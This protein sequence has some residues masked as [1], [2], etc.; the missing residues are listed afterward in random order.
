MLEPAPPPTLF[1]SNPVPRSAA[2]AAGLTLPASLAAQLAALRAVMAR[3]KLREAA[4]A[5]VLAFT[6]GYLAVYTVDRWFDT[7]G[8][9]RLVALTLGLIVGAVLVPLAYLRWVRAFRTPLAVARRAALIDP[10]A[11]DRVL[12]VLELCTNTE[13]LRRSPELTRAA[14]AA[15]DRDLAG[16]SLEHVA[17]RSRHQGLTS[18][19]AVA[20]AAVIALVCVS[21]AAA[22]SSLL[23]YLAP[24]GAV[25]RY[26]FTQVAPYV[27]H[28]IVARDEPFMLEF[29]LASTTRRTPERARLTGRAP[30]RP[31]DATR[32]G[33]RYRFELP[34][35]LAATELT[36]AVGDAFERVTVEPLDRPEVLAL[37]A[38]VRL[39]AYLE[40]PEPLQRDAR[41][42]RFGAVEGSQ[43]RLVGEISRELASAMLERDGVT[44]AAITEGARFET[45]AFTPEASGTVALTWRDVHG[46]APAAPFHLGVVLRADG[47]PTVLLDGLDPERPLLEGVA[48]KFQVRG[49]DDFGLRR[50][51]LEFEQASDAE[52]EA[53]WSKVAERVLGSGAPDAQQLALDATLSPSADGLAPG[54]VRLRAWAEDSLPGRGRVHSAPVVLLVMSADEHMRWVTRQLSAWTDRA[55][56][57]RDT[58][59]ALLQANEALLALPDADLEGSEARG[60]LREQA[61][62]ERANARRLERVVDDGRELLTEAARNSEFNANVLDEWAESMRDLERLADAGMPEVA[63]RLADA[64]EARALAKAAASAPRKPSDKAG[65]S[66]KGAQGSQGDTPSKPDEAESPPSASS[67]P[68]GEGSPPPG[69]PGKKPEEV[70]SAGAGAPPPDVPPLPPLED[71]ESSLGAAPAPAKPDEGAAPAGLPPAPSLSLLNTTL[72]S[73]PPPDGDGPAHDE[74]TPEESAPEE[75]PTREALADAVQKQRALME[76]LQRITGEIQAVLAALEGSTFVKRLKAL[77]RVETGV[78]DTLGAVVYTELGHRATQ[79][80]TITPEATAVAAVQDSAGREAAEIRSDLSAFVERLRSTGAETGGY[81]TVVREMVDYGVALEMVAIEDL[82][83]VRRSGEALTSAEALADTLDRWAEEIVGPG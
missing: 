33:D 34:G 46:L 18:L 60:K 54:F 78:A 81:E 36:L 8:A 5:G 10:G 48:L 66:A 74:E 49:N 68:A 76:E 30:L 7:P 37:T 29:Q 45:A 83:R 9:A 52:R 44:H 69:E 31:L 61:S 35:V 24:F 1:D 51:G 17:P 57:V 40:L 70:A 3:T 63:E 21:P 16:G 39:P 77:S 23:R 15:A 2:A 20:L 32:E 65:P 82:A 58:E 43:L 38:E 47:A 80:D 27:E 62:L 56:E 6:A 28:P 13:E 72:G 25:E 75:S 41:S 67:S 71:R 73:A 4:A 50:L 59:A 55:R 12:G 19:A 64:A 42:G 26:T 53:A 79:R 22:W 14:V 11:G